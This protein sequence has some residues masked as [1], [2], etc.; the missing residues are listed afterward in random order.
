[1]QIIIDEISYTMY[2][3]KMT[4]PEGR[5]LWVF[6]STNGV[7]SPEWEYLGRI[8]PDGYEGEIVYR[9]N[10]YPEDLCKFPTGKCASIEGIILRC[11]EL[12]DRLM[13]E[14]E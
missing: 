13:A 12:H 5:T 2:E 6:P 8:V 9:G 7:A 4:F 1:M 10:S 11:E 14:Y 3:G